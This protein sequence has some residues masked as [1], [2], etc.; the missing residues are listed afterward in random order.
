MTHPEVLNPLCTEPCEKS[1][2]DHCSGGCSEASPLPEIRNTYAYQLMRSSFYNALDLSFDEVMRE[3]KRILMIGGCRQ[4]DF[5]QHIA[6]ILPGSEIVLV[7]P[8]PLETQKAKEEI[9]CR[10]KFIDAPLEALPFE[11]DSFDLTFGHNMLAYAQDWQK[12]LSEV[13]RVTSENFFFSFHQPVTWSIAKR[14]PHMAAALK[15]MGIDQLPQ[16]VPDTNDLLTQIRLYATP[17][18]R[19]KPFPWNVWMSTMHPIREEKLVLA[20]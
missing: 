16:Q 1:G 15:E 3:P 5:A 17:K 2:T 6:L 14:F 20:S 19:F 7:D 10:F 9:C 18:T 13:G 11:A 12:A 8:D 4:R